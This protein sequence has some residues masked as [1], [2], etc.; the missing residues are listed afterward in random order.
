MNAKHYKTYIK[1][2]LNILHYRKEQGL[3]QEEL[4]EMTNYSRNHIQK[5]ETAASVPSVDALLDIA[6]ALD[7]PP[8]KLFEF[9]D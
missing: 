5:I 9:K 2:G 4:A 1:I 7:I 8:C 6:K 3:T